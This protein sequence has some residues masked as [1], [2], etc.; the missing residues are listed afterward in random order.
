MVLKYN[1]NNK[2][3]Y[4]FQI[5]S[6]KLNLTKYLLANNVIIKELTTEFD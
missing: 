4:V 6:D 2:A 3:T 1:V 5:S